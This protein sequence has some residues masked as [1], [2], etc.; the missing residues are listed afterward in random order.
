MPGFMT[1]VVADQTPDSSLVIGNGAG[2]PVT[3]T[4]CALGARRRKVT[5]RSAETSGD[6]RAAPRPPPPP[7]RPPAWVAGGGVVGACAVW[8]RSG[9]TSRHTAS[10]IYTTLRISMRRPL[11]PYDLRL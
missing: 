3:A 7:A 4:S 8:A 2:K 11:M 5:V 9:A 6:R 10:D 1:A